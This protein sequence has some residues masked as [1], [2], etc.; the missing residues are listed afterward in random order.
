LEIHSFSASTVRRSIALFSLSLFLSVGQ[1]C[2]DEFV[3]GYSAEGE[4][5]EADRPACTEV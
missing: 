4:K 3:L 2:C 1:D 5:Q